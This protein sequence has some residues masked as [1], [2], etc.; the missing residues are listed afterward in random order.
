MVD[1]FIAELYDFEARSR[2]LASEEGWSRDVRREMVELGLFA[3]PFAED[4]GGGGGGGVETMIVMEVLGSGC[5]SA[6]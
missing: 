3:I 1:R 5:R 6:E 4:D 2:I